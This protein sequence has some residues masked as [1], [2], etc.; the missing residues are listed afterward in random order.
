MIRFA[1]ISD[2]APMLA[3]YAPFVENTTA[4]FE[5]AVPTLE[6]FAARFMEKTE[7]FPWL[8]WEEDGRVLGYAYGSAPFERAAYGWCAEVSIYLHP[9]VH[10]RGIGRKL[11]A[12]VEEL[13]RRQG[14]WKVYAIV[15]SENLASIA[16]HKAVGYAT[17]AVFPDCGFK[18]GR[19]IG[20]VWLEKQLNSGEMPTEPPASI[21]DIVKNHR[22]LSEVLDKMPLS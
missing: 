19:W 18:F 22:N 7:R 6:R 15:T 11:Y 10:G 8:V 5:Y 17:T 1:E 20:T 3:I 21:W 2:V 13:L 12:V 4:S 16:F 9:S 14:F